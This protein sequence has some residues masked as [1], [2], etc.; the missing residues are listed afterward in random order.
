MLEAG[1]GAQC[2]SKQPDTRAQLRTKIG[3]AG[4]H[5]E[6]S[7]RNHDGGAQGGKGDRNAC[8]EEQGEI[9]AC[10]LQPAGH[11]SYQ[12][13]SLSL[14]CMWVARG[15]AEYAA[16]DDETFVGMA[17]AAAFDQDA[18][19]EKKAL[20]APLGEG[21]DDGS[22]IFARQC[23]EPTWMVFRCVAGACRS[24][25]TRNHLFNIVEL[26]AG[27]IPPPA[28]PTLPQTRRLFLATNC[29]PRN[30]PLLLLVGCIAKHGMEQT[31]AATGDM[32]RKPDRCSRRDVACSCNNSGSRHPSH[33]LDSSLERNGTQTKPR[34]SR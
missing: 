28:G 30:C 22:L 9:K 16:A 10:W 13:S 5:I 25:S 17:S 29:N 15:C 14:K 11:A 23:L 19:N 18:T 20:H 7:V 2:S 6:Q 1:D 8:G 32:K 24:L 3:G 12:I 27:L 34:R 21:Q 4:A 26:G 31:T 33:R